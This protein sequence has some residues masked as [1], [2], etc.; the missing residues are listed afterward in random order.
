[1]RRGQVI[2]SRKD[3][4]TVQGFDDWPA[5]D[6]TFGIRRHHIPDE[7]LAQFN[8]I[9]IIV[10]FFIVELFEFGAWIVLLFDT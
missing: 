6:L 5:F 4:N 7:N 10:G 9:E 1:M 3:L 8:L 2:A